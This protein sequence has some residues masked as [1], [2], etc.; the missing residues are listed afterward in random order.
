VSEYYE[1][2]G[3]GDTEQI[4]AEQIHAEFT[5]GT[6]LTLVDV[7]GDG[8]ADAVVYDAGTHGGYDEGGDAYDDAA[9]AGHDGGEAGYTEPTGDETYG[10]YE[11]YGDYG[12]YPAGDAYGAGYTDG[13]SFYANDN[14]GT[15]VSTNPGGDEGYIALGDGEFVS[16][17]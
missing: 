8:Y 17:G 6:S 12:T 13:G 14:L 5:D 15:A 11:E 9:Q 4:H 7:D 10:Q 1:A 2:D 16:W 3:H